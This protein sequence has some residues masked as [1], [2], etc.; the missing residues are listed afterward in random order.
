MAKD[1]KFFTTTTII[2]LAVVAIACCVVSSSS[3][4][5]LLGPGAN[6]PDPA[7]DGL[8]TSPRTMSNVKYQMFASFLFNTRSDCYAFNKWA[9]VTVPENLERLNVSSP[10]LLKATKADLQAL[11]LQV[12]PD[13]SCPAGTIVRDPPM[14]L[15]LFVTQVRTNL[16]KDLAFIQGVGKL[17]QSLK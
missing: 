9:R 1:G 7:Y 3:A 12:F 5:L 2:A 14:D 13:I 15:K 8:P 16:T 11:A 4:F 17:E 6:T 10:W